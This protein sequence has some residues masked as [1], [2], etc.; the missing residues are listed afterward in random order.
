MSMSHKIGKM[1]IELNQEQIASIIQT[2]L[3]WDENARLDNIQF[4]IFGEAEVLKIRAIAIFTNL[5][6][7][8]IQ[9][10]TENGL[11]LRENNIKEAY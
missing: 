10:N 4:Y 11:H 8:P 2:R 9:N 5:D 1:T 3:E 7:T 6:P